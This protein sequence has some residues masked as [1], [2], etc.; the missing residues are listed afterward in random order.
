MDAV[1][2]DNPPIVI[3]T[4]GM[5]IDIPKAALELLA[6]KRIH[7]AAS[8][9]SAEHALLS[10]LPNFVMSNEGE[11]R[12]E[13]KVALKENMPTESNRKRPARLTLYDA[14]GGASGSG[15]SL[16]AFEFIHVLLK[17]AITRL[18][19]CKCKNGCPSCTSSPLC[20]GEI[21]NKVGA[22]VILRLLA[23]EEVDEESIPMGEEIDEQHAIWSVSVASEVRTLEQ[24]RLEAE[25]EDREIVEIKA[26]P[27]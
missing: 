20:T 13:C 22:G 11:V 4:K 21:Q 19:Q 17:Q 2:V 9:H 14:K 16:K 6:R 1:D 26:E 25:Q 18:D 3:F 23:G 8:I 15:L 27:E 5:W 7:C 12:T 24:R 10:L